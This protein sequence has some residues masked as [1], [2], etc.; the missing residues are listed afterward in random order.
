[1]SLQNLNSS[2][3]AQL[4]CIPTSIPTTL[5]AKHLSDSREINTFLSLRV[6]FRAILHILPWG[7]K[8]I[9]RMYN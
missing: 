4:L 8:K 7:G 9:L 1:L 5:R 3:V 2:W 6:K